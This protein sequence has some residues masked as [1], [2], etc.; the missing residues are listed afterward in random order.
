MLSDGIFTKCSECQRTHQGRYTLPVSHE[1]LSPRGQI[2]RGGGGHCAHVKESFPSSV[3][4]QLKCVTDLLCN[5]T[6]FVL[7]CPS[8]TLVPPLPLKSRGGLLHRWAHYSFADRRLYHMKRSPGASLSSIHP[9]PP[10]TSSRGKIA[11][12]RFRHG[13]QSLAGGFSRGRNYYRT[14]AVSTRCIQV[15]L[16]SSRRTDCFQQ[17]N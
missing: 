6:D 8:V 4:Y 16:S 14:P 1:N 11:G 17:N 10:E 5:F 7:C 3:L 13:I 9:L 15:Y 2:R 12:R